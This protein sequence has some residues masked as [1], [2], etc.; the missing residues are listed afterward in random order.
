[1]PQFYPALTRPALRSNSPPARAVL[2]AVVLHHGVKIGVD[3][4]CPP[5]PPLGVVPQVTVGTRIWQSCS[6]QQQPQ[7]CFRA[8]LGS[9][10]RQIQGGGCASRSRSLKLFHPQAQ[11]FDG[12]ERPDVP[13]VELV[14]IEHE[15]V[16]GNHEL[17]QGQ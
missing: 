16:S 9:L 13:W 2:V 17:I 10:P 12:C 1:M 8:G 3:E 4:V 7:Q 11:R 15:M 14:G 5:E 6:L